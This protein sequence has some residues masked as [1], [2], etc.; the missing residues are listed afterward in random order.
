MLIGCGEHTSASSSCD[1]LRRVFVDYGLRGWRG[2]IVSFITRKDPAEAA[3]AITTL[4]GQ[5]GIE[6]LPPSGF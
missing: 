4:N 3:L 1:D 6:E 5:E 2:P